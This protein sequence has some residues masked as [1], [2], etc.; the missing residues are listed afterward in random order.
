MIY[1][2][3]AGHLAIKCLEKGYEVSNLKLQKLMYY[4]QGYSIAIIGE[5]AFTDKVVA[6]DNGPVVV[7]LYHDLK[8]YGYNDIPLHYFED[9]FG[10]F[11]QPSSA[12]EDVVDFVVKIYG[13]KS[14]NELVTSTHN[15][16]P[17]LKHSIDGT[18]DGTSDN[19]E[20]TTLELREHFQSEALNLFGESIVYDAIDAARKGSITVPKTIQSEDDF[21]AWMTTPQ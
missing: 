16:S 9:Q 21:V 13:P 10:M 5:K 7:P 12:I 14:A 11:D 8:C 15:E 4:V 19:G 6:W 3:V 18:P 1:K 20:I 17:W 2:P